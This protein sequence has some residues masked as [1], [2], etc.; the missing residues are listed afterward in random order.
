MKNKRKCAGKTGGVPAALQR[1]GE[2]EGERKGEARKRG[3][4][5]RGEVKGK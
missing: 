3:G 2:G 5:G 4:E 1:T